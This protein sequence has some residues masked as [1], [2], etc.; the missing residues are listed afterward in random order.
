MFFSIKG[1]VLRD[2][3]DVK[4]DLE[5]VFPEHWM[6]NP[7][8]LYLYLHETKYFLKQQNSFFCKKKE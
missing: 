2:W 3:R 1:T 6:A 7:T 5:P 8:S 4:Y